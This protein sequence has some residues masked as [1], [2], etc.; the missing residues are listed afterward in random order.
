MKNNQLLILMP[1]GIN[2]VKEIFESTNTVGLHTLSEH[3]WV[4]KSDHVSNCHLCT[5]PD[6]MI[7]ELQDLDDNDT[8]C[9]LLD[10]YG[11]VMVNKFIHH[12]IDVIK[13]KLEKLINYYLK[14]ICETDTTDIIIF[15][16]MSGSKD[17]IYDIINECFGP[18][19][20]NLI[21]DVEE[22][23]LKKCFK[24]ANFHNIHKVSAYERI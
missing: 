9:N 5:I 17:Y 2:N 22:C 15:N 20:S 8:Y 12:D 10:T 4:V 16:D 14:T 11:N 3:Y 1:D 13:D 7:T 23:G 18:A 21:T 6:I 19:G 24:F